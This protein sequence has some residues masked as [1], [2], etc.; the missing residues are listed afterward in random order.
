[1]LSSRSACEPRL[2]DAD[3]RRALV[4]QREPVGRLEGEAELGM[5]EAAPEREP[6]RGIV[7]EGD[8]VDRAEIGVA[9][10]VADAGRRRSAAPARPPAAMRSGVEG[11]V[12]I[13]SGLSAEP[14]PIIEARSALQRPSESRKREAA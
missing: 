4:F 13:M 6:L 10:G 9:R 14:S 12:A 11:W 7:A 8:A 3:Q 2:A 1:M 5:Q